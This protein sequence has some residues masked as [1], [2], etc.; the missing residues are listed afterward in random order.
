MAKLADKAVQVELHTRAWT[1]IATDREIASK[2]ENEYEAEKGT[3]RVLKELTPKSYMQQIHRIR[4]YGRNEHY[5]ITVPG[6]ARNQHILPTSLVEEYVMVQQAIKDEFFRAVDNFCEEYP[7]ILKAAPD[8]L[9]G[10]YKEGDFPTEAQIRNYFEYRHRMFPLPQTSDWRLEGV[11]QDMTVELRNE[12]EDEVRSMY[13]RAAE[14]LYDR[15]RE[16]ME[17]IAKQAENYNQKSSLK[18]VTINNLKEFANLLPNLNVMDDPI[19]KQVAKEMQDEFM[20][21]DVGSLKEN[22]DERTALADRAR[23][24]IARLGGQ[25]TQDE[26]EKRI[27]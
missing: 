18:A 4:T 1:A 27:A 3:L 2:T 5:R 7:S 24:V 17:N 6:L 25:K 19:L 8:R 22:E 21:L 16:T 10:A 13:H 20:T 11:P 9:K 14:E 15:V 23:S 12:V 26:R